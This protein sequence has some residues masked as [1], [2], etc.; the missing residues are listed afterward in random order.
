MFDGNALKNETVLE[1]CA[2]FITLCLNKNEIPNY[3]MIS[4][5]IMFSKTNSSE[6]SMD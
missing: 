4:K 1:N 5:L 3:L 2:R 6:A